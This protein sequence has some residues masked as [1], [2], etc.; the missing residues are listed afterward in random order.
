MPLS[1]SDWVGKPIEVCLIEPDHETMFWR[2]DGVWF[3][4]AAYAEEHGRSWFEH[5]DDA[6]VLAGSVLQGFDGSESQYG[7]LPSPSDID[8]TVDVQFLRFATSKGRCTIE[9]RT[10]HDPH[11]GGWVEIRES[12]RDTTVT[13]VILGSF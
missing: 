3:T 12:P 11:Y 7:E 1:F 9:L 8:R 4:I 13:A 6:S 5:C 10:D 2:I